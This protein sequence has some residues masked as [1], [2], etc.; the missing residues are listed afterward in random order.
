MVALGH[1]FGKAA[2][3]AHAKL[4]EGTDEADFYKAKIVT[5]RFSF[6]RLLPPA[7]ALVLAIKRGKA[8]MMELPAEAF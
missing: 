5:A 4:A 1:C 7:S 2:V 3:L 6:D 8:S